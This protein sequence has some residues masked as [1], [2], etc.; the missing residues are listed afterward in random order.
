VFSHGS[1]EPIDADSD[2]CA[3]ARQNGS[4]TLLVAVNLYPWRSTRW[5]ERKLALPPQ[6]KWDSFQPVAGQ[7]GAKEGVDLF[8]SMPVLVA[9]SPD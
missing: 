7:L 6:L 2:I 4:A 9:F 1:Y 8:L 3:F 5:T